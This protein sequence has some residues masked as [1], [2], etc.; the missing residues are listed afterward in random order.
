MDDTSMGAFG[1]CLT[2]ALT[3]L[4]GQ[5]QGDLQAALAGMQPSGHGTLC[6]P[7]AA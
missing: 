7:P 6:D 2:P 3:R 5:L 4:A 1:V